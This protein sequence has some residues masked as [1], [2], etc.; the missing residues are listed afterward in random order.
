[1]G[2]HKNIDADKF[3]EQDC[4]LGVQVRVCFNY[5]GRIF[6]GIVVR[7]DKESP[8]I[9][10]IKLED[11]RHV[12]STECEWRPVSMEESLSSRGRI[13]SSNT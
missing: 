6:L 1:M 2:S 10:I 4:Y 9:T 11:G 5:V 12:L 13:L 3:P 8:G 7:N